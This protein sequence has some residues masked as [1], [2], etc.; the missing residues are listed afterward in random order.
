[1]PTE[2][3][4]TSELWA[5]EDDVGRLRRAVKELSILNDLARD[6]SISLDSQHIT[7]TIIHRSLRAIGAEQGV[8]ALLDRRGDGGMETLV[9]T[10][11]GPSTGQ[12]L[13]VQE[14]LLGWMQLN[15]RPLLVNNPHEDPRFPGVRWDESISSLL[16]VPL[17]VKSELTGVLIVFNK[18]GT[19]GFN[20]DDQRLLSIL[21][22]QSAQV[23][24]SARLREEEA[25]L[26]RFQDEL[27]LASDIQLGL[28]PKTMPVLPDF[29]IAGRNTP[30]EAI[31]GD[32]FDFIELGDGRLAIC[33]ADVS[34]KGL[35]ASLLMANLQ[36]TVRAQALMQLSPGRCLRHSNT[37][38]CKSTD[39][40]KFATCFYAV[41][42]PE[43]GEVR[44]SNAGHDPPLLLSSGGETSHLD[45][46][47]VVLGFLEHTDYEEEVVWLNPGDTLVMYSDGV[48]DAEDEHGHQFGERRL[49]DVVRKHSVE[50]SARV[51]E[52]VMEAVRVHAGDQGQ[53]DDVT[54]VVVRRQG[55]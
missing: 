49:C 12:A 29:D 30:A 39:L 52:S 34:G 17:L 37:L 11:V 8:I 43:N 53:S 44:Y 22:A 6:I 47:G 25:T 35:S 54:V 2:P 26:R 5:P 28:L 14:S 46:G 40:H 51:V 10:L 36:A 15:K 23:V 1:V 4:P 24:E 7:N 41:L 19:G 9:R 55:A 3:T 31:G 27:E 33:I 42:A 45:S 21:A 38:L 50:P 13:H 18:T 16:C 20:E 32:Y 48:T